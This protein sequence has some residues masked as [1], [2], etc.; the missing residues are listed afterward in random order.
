MTTTEGARGTTSEQCATGWEVLATAWKTGKVTTLDQL[1]TTDLAYHMPPFPDM[2]LEALKT[3]IQDFTKGFPDFGLHTDEQIISGSTSVHRWHC[4][5]T[6]SGDTPLLP[7]PATGRHT[8]AS[9]NLILHWREG[10]IE[11]V[12]HLGDWLGWLTQAGVVAPL[13][14]T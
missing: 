3:C 10:Q 5:G 12:W 9:G 6:F 13:G 4:D 11:E 7:V 14:P 2:G 8:T 1:F